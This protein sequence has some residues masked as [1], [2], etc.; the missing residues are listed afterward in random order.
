MLFRSGDFIVT[1]YVTFTYKDCSSHLCDGNGCFLHTYVMVWQI[2]C[3]FSSA[4]RDVNE[5]EI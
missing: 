1:Y 3:I 4:K 5:K 2:V